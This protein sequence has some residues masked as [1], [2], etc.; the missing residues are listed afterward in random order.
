[1]CKQNIK[2]KVSLTQNGFL[3]RII[4]LNGFIASVYKQVVKEKVGA[5]ESVN[6]VTG[7]KSK[8]KQGQ[9]EELRA[10]KIGLE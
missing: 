2:L 3:N 5:K 4:V 9:E 6:R 7:D 1:M 10:R 8:D